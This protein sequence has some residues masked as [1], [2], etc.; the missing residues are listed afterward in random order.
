MSGKI[1][2]KFTEIFSV[3]IAFI[4]FIENYFLESMEVFLN[5]SMNG[6][7]DKSSDKFLG[8][9]LKEFPKQSEE[10]YEYIEYCKNIA[11]NI[12]NFL[13]SEMFF[14]FV[15]APTYQK[16]HADVSDSNAGMSD[17]SQAF[18]H[19]W[20]D[21]PEKAVPSQIE[22]NRAHPKKNYTAI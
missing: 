19:A 1:F 12:S 17:L 8:E 15:S 11:W 22:G 18:R 7:L 20:K 13:T 10:I 5:I 3:G 16:S 14:K 4:E 21:G 9:F 6:F 2:Y